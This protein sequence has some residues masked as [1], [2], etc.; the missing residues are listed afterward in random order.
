MKDSP[1][2][3]MD[4]AVLI[5]WNR[6]LAGFV[7]EV[8]SGCVSSPSMANGFASILADNPANHFVGK[9]KSEMAPCVANAI[10][11]HIHI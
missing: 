9:I 10:H 3:A 4:P 7:K 8:P 2:S 6:S 11:V 5:D 1:N